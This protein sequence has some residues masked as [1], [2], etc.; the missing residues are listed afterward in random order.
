MLNKSAQKGSNKPGG[1]ASDVFG[2]LLE[3]GKKTAKTAKKQLSGK[4]FAQTAGQQIK[5]SPP[6]SPTREAGKPLPASQASRSKDG[7]P[8]TQMSDAQFEQIKRQRQLQAMRRYREIQQELQKYRRKKQQEIPR[9][10]SGKAGFDEEAALSGQAPNKKDQKAKR[11]L[12]QTSS[13]KKRGS[14][15]LPRSKRKNMGTGELSRGKTG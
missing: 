1:I 2:Q 7:M 11:P 12:P 15:F 10:V 6:P 4:K 5:G 8:V 3:T 13:K 14:A 9:Q